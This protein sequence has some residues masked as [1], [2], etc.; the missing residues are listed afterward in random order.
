M[1]FIALMGPS[2]TWAQ[3]SRYRVEVLVL[4]H[5]VHDEEAL[6]LAWPTDYSATI[7]FLTPPEE[8]EANEDP[9]S[10]VTDLPAAAEPGLE[11]P[12]AGSAD[13]SETVAPEN[14]EPTEESG[15]SG[16]V[17][18]EDMSEAMREAWRRL[19][20]SGPF[21]PLQFLAWEQS[22]EAPFPALRIHDSEV[23]LIDDSYADLRAAAT[24]GA[25]RANAAEPN[26]A[27]ALPPPTV[28]YRLDGSVTLRKTRFLHL[29]LDIELREA[30]HEEVLDARPE[31]FRVYRLQQSRQIK[32]NS[33]SYFDGPVFGVLA[34]LTSIEPATGTGTEDE[35][36][37]SSP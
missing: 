19:R 20:L 27:D 10:A 17:P 18:V 15:F 11:T 33:M 2:T 34:Y 25:E 32:T 14:T 37:P 24:A 31:A 12:A 3:E 4:S 8:P 9:G 36:A 35:A 22:A 29:D 26:A 7:D 5:L 23:L 1:S 21:R 30:V 16:P 28:Y 6:E 13:G